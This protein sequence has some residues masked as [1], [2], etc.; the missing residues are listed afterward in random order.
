[1]LLP[2]KTSFLFLIPIIAA[3]TNSSQPEQQRDISD[4][5]VAS[6]DPATEFEEAKREC[7]D[8]GGEWVW[9]DHGDELE[10]YFNIMRCWSLDDPPRR[11]GDGRWG[12]PGLL[13]FDVLVRYSRETNKVTD[14][15]RFE[16]NSK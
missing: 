6:P 13:P 7:A 15:G 5:I 14:F 16:P 12:E 1:M 10:H 8:K 3:C 11:P 9:Y 2:L 4:L